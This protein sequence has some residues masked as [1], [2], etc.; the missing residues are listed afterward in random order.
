MLPEG[1]R[2]TTGLIGRWCKCSNVLSLSILIV[3]EAFP[4]FT[5]KSSIIKDALSRISRKQADQRSAKIYSI[6]IF[7]RTLG[8]QRLPSS[9][10]IGTQQLPGRPCTMGTISRRRGCESIRRP[11]AQQLGGYVVGDHPFPFRTRKLRPTEPMVL[12]VRRVG[13]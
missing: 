3:R 9:L 6:F 11:C 10:Q 12:P 1:P 13:E 2:K 4:C 5:S 7:Q 8:S